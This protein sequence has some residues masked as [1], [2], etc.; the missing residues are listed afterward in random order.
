MWLASGEAMRSRRTRSGDTR[1]FRTDELGLR[2]A[3]A[4]IESRHLVLA[5]AFR[6]YAHL[7]GVVLEHARGCGALS[8]LITDSLGCP[9]VRLAHH[10]LVSSSTGTLLVD[11][12][13]PAVFCVEALCDLVIQLSRQ[14]LDTHG[15]R[16][17][18]HTPAPDH[19]GSA[20]P[21]DAAR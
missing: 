12:S 14:R 10:V 6:R 2:L 8:M 15:R 7:T 19:C 16:V 21:A 17:P 5:F 3:L 4:E 9:F 13:I 20:P 1:L 11:S 18:E